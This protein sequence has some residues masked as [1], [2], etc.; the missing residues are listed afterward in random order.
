MNGRWIA[1]IKSD[2][3]FIRIPIQPEKKHFATEKM[4]FSLIDLFVNE[5]KAFHREPKIIV[6]CGISIRKYR[7]CRYD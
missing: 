1:F 5:R 7:E 4:Y 2:D 3:V 6:I